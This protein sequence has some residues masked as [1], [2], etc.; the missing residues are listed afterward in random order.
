MD[1]RDE[2]FLALGRA[3]GSTSPEAVAKIGEELLER[4]NQERPE[5]PPKAARTEISNTSAV[6]QVAYQPSVLGSRRGPVFGFARS[7]CG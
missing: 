7:E 2:V 1:L 4:I 3:S 6:S 5:P